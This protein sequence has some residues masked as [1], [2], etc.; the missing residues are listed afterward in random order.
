MSSLFVLIMEIGT[1]SVCKIFVCFVYFQSV[2]CIYACVCIVFYVAKKSALVQQ[3]KLALMLTL[4]YLHWH[5][6]CQL[7]IVLHCPNPI[8]E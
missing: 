3:I 6:C 1:R 4:T 2:L 7:S 5:F 8:N